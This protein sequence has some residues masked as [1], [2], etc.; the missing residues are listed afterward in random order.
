MN[1]CEG[2]RN[3]EG[4]EMDRVA[5]LMDGWSRRQEVQER[6]KGMFKDNL[7]TFI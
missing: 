3:K 2:E 1:G 5:L 6:W 4:G 7:G